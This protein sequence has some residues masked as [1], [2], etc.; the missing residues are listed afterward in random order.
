VGSKDTTVWM[1]L[2]STGT[3]MKVRQPRASNLVEPP[4]T[5]LSL[6]VQVF[7]GHEG[8]VTCGLFTADG[9]HVCTG[10]SDA[11]PASTLVVIAGSQLKAP[12][13]YV[14]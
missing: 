2:A 14:S 12:H 7:S 9:K 3:C 1:W 10:P 5:S 4:L 6:P 8:E 11:G 13:V